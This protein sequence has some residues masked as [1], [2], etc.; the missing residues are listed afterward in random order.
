ME[1][2][3]QVEILGADATGDPPRAVTDER[4]FTS[5]YEQAHQDVAKGLSLAFADP[6]LGLEATDEAFTR[7][8]Q[9]WEQ[10]ATMTNPTGWVYR[11]GLNWGRSRL[12]RLLLHDRRKTLLATRADYDARL[13]DVDLWR[14]LSALPQLQRDVV[15][16]RVVLDWT[17]DA[18]AEVLGIAGGTVKSRLARAMATLR[19]ELEADSEETR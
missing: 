3:N 16:L 6:E 2:L 13:V 8:Y 11:V 1:W 18:T 9:R 10:V 17:V 4:S 15:V 19:A 7:A 5:F 14:A 12:R